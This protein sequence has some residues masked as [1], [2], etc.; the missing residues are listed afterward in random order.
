MKF[1]IILSILTL[2]F[3]LSLFS[4]EIEIRR[5]LIPNFVQSFRVTCIHNKVSQVEFLRFNFKDGGSSL[6]NKNEN[7]MYKISN[8]NELAGEP[9]Y[10]KL[11]NKQKF[12]V[13]YINI[14]NRDLQSYCLQFDSSLN[15]FWDQIKVTMLK[16]IKAFQVVKKVRKCIP[17][18]GFWYGSPIVWKGNFK[19]YSYIKFDGQKPLL[20]NTSKYK[21][22]FQ[23][24]SDC[25]EYRSS[26]QPTNE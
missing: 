13:G 17:K 1:S 9:V 10:I 21:H 22:V 15:Y 3:S 6:L 12:L 5:S 26:I 19:A 23:T 20:L 2:S 14:K 18:Q 8:L 11:E 7:L 24:Q 16:T 4:K 25:Q